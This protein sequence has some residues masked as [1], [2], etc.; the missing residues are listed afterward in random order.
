MNHNPYEHA[1]VIGSS[2]AGLITTAIL[3]RHFDRVT[4]IERDRLPDAVELRKGV[5]QATQAHILLKRGQMIMEDLF[6]GMTDE[7]IAA[8]AVPLNM[9][10]DLRWFVGGWRPRFESSIEILGVSRPLLETTIRQHL[11]AN[12]KVMFMQDTRVIGLSSDTKHSRATGVKVEQRYMG[13]LIVSADLVVDAS[14]R[15]TH[16]PEWLKEL[17]FVPPEKTQVNAHAG[18]SSRYYEMDSSLD[19]KAMYVQPTPAGGSRGGVLLP[20]DGNRWHVGLVGIAGDYPPSDDDAFLEWARGMATPDFYEAIKNARPLGA[21][22]AYRTAENRMYHYDQ[23]PRYLE[24]FVAI[25]DSV[26]AFNPVYGQGM[27]VAAVSALDLDQSL[28]VQRSLSDDLTGLAEHF[29]KSLGATL[30]MPWQLATGEDMRWP[31]TEI[32][33]YVPP[34]TPEMLEMGAYMDKVFAAAGRDPGV[35]EIFLKVQNMV[36][37]PAAFFQPDVMALVMANSEAPAPAPEPEFA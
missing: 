15:A 29:Q 6:P 16:A 37:S 9:G 24:N 20:N 28:R 10:A 19:W 25:G 26:F 7:L 36:E 14:G 2:I 18:Y 33:G 3:T 27:T 11:K 5:P 32:E 34:P 22:V 13:E 35:L 8:G 12:P 31:G 23:L 17:G 4:V 30:A 21:A 1:V